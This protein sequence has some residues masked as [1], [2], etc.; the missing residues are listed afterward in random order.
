MNQKIH[1]ASLIKTGYFCVMS[2]RKQIRNDFTEL[3]VTDAGATG[4]A[5]PQHPAM[6][7]DSINNVLTVY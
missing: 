1:R 3:E 4:K 5:L 6:Q 2:R 7:L